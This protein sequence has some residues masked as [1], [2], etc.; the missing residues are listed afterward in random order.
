M[1]KMLELKEI[2]NQDFNCLIDLCFEVSSHFTLTKK[3][4]ALSSKEKTT[5]I[6]FLKEMEPY[7]IEK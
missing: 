4:G 6:A 3:N 7:L 5:Y 1:S 2:E